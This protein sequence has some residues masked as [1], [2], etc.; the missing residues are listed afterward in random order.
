MVSIYIR[1]IKR[2]E[3]YMSTGMLAR[4]MYNFNK[5]FHVPLFVVKRR[6]NLVCS[7]ENFQLKGEKFRRCDFIDFSEIDVNIQLHQ[8]NSTT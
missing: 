3:D 1:A 2:A 5:K 6:T 4:I 8:H 7:R